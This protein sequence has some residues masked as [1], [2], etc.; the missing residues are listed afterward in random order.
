MLAPENS[1]AWLVYS[2]LTTQ[3]ISVTTGLIRYDAELISALCGLLGV[4]GLAAVQLSG[5]ILWMIDLTNSK[6]IE[7][8][9]K[10]AKTP[11]GKP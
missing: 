7:Q 2:A 4:E 8:M 1:D 5:K 6:R 11:K 9:E 10:E 3:S